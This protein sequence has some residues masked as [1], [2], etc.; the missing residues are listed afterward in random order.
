MAQSTT[1]PRMLGSKRIES[2]AVIVLEFPAGTHLHD[3]VAYLP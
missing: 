3:L 2:K 1:S